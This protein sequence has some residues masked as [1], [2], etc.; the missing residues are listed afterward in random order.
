MSN[1][2]PTVAR[3]SVYRR[4]VAR[5]GNRVC[6]TRN[7]GRCARHR[8]DIPSE[9]C[10]AVGPSLPGASR[11]VRKDSQLRCRADLGSGPGLLPV[12]WVSG[13]PRA[14]QHCP[15]CWG[16]VAGAVPQE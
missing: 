16:D 11:F 6:E 12:T 4:C 10:G 8:A 9:T 13:L 14:L 3:L 15:L 7:R 5:P 2:F 1:D